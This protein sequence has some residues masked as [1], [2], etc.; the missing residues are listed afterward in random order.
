MRSL[1][2]ALAALPSS[3][4]RS[5]TRQPLS[6]RAAAAEPRP[7][8]C[9]PAELRA[10]YAITTPADTERAAAVA[11]AHA[12]AALRRW[13]ENRPVSSHTRAAFALVEAWLAARPAGR[14]I[15]LDLG[16]GT[17]RSSVRIAQREPSWDVLGVDRNAQLLEKCAVLLGGGD[18]GDGR[19]SRDSRGDRAGRRVCGDAP[20]NVA[21]VRADQQDF[22][23]L[24]AESRWAT[25]VHRVFALYAS[26]YPKPSGLKSRIY[27]APM[28]PLLLRL[29]ADGGGGVLEARA[30][31]P[32]FLEEMAAASRALYPSSSIVT[33][34]CRIDL[35]DCSDA[36][37]NFEEKYCRCGLT[38]YGVKIKL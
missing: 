9:T 23:R 28:F 10:R 21:V 19:D 13:H 36:M 5:A 20:E 11:V 25:S 27:G 26:P 30:S 6:I 2:F 1:G 3:R 24:L 12:G 17:G 38:V 22:L 34:P 33:G 18:G 35:A 32:A 8:L 16:C 14:A 4:R 15:A 37:S 29:L 31:W 7:A